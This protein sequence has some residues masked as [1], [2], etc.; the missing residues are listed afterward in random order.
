MRGKKD[1]QIWNTVIIFY[2]FSLSF[3]F[4]LLFRFTPVAYGISQ[5]RG[6]IRATADG[7]PHSHS[8]SN[9]IA[10]ATPWPQQQRIQAVS[11]TCTTAHSKARSLIHWVGPGVE[12]ASSRLLARFVTGELQ[13]E[14]HYILCIV[15]PFSIY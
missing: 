13:W 12:P 2:I 7:L 1:T 14:L 9:T 3:F 8:H 5:A 4:P 11:V 15:N 6:W 10:T